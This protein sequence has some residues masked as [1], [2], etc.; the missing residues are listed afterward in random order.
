MRLALLLLLLIINQS[1][2][3]NSNSDHNNVN[4]V[5]AKA[6]KHFS[7]QTWAG[8]E[9]FLGQVKFEVPKEH[10]LQTSTDGRAIEVI[11]PIR[12]SGPA[13]CS[14]R[15]RQLFSGQIISS[16]YDYARN[17]YSGSAGP[18]VTFLFEHHPMV[19]VNQ[20]YQSGQNLAFDKRGIVFLREYVLTCAQNGNW[21]PDSFAGFMKRVAKGIKLQY[22]HKKLVSRRV[23]QLMTKRTVRG[24]E[25][26]Y[27]WQ[28]AGT[29]YTEKVLTSFVLRPSQKV[30]ILDRYERLEW[31]GSG[32]LVQGDFQSILNDK[33]VYK[34]ALG[35]TDSG[36][37]LAAGSHKGQSF[38]RRIQGPRYPLLPFW[39]AQNAK[40][41]DHA[42]FYDPNHTPYRFINGTLSNPKPNLFNFKSKFFK[43]RIYM[44]DQGLPHRVIDRYS[45]Q[46]YYRLLKIK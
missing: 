5:K 13:M 29:F 8:V 2:A 10:Q 44:D 7:F 46:N 30:R 4:T 38:Q 42:S 39:D 18:D 15:P 20:R 43:T 24:F 3:T 25:S 1:C 23:Y 26:H 32:E 28:T 33:V 27:L 16:N 9:G 37:Y 34:I 40:Q 22:P 17:Q 11:V 36:M 35:P 14:V 19:I 31:N 6:G 45:K 21:H 12:G 41:L